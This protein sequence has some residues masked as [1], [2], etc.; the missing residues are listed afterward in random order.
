LVGVRGRHPPMAAL[1]VDLHEVL[2]FGE[3]VA[4]ERRLESEP[5]RELGRRRGPICTQEPLERKSARLMRILLA[6]AGPACKVD[7]CGA[8]AL[9]WSV[10]HAAHRGPPADRQRLARKVAGPGLV[11]SRRPLAY[12]PLDLSLQGL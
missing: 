5:S 10:A 3:H 8:T 9:P 2:R 6:P 1:D 7:E 11:A 12:A 4:R